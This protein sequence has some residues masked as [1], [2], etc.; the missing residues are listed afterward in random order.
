MHTGLG[1]GGRGEVSDSLVLPVK[2]GDMLPE[3][4]DVFILDVGEFSRL[5]IS[6]ELKRGE[7]GDL[8]GEPGLELLLRG[9]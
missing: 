9:A 8:M 7:V 6:G 3:S 5:R 4:V 1:G 2:R